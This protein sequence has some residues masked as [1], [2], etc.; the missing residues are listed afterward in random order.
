MPRLLG[1]I[2]TLDNSQKGATTA[3]VNTFLT[4]YAPLASPTFTGTP[5]APTASVGTNTTQIATTA[6]V[7]A[8]AGSSSS[9][10]LAGNAGTTP[11]TQFI[12]T[13]DAQALKFRVNNV[14]QVSIE[15]SGSWRLGTPSAPG[16]TGMERLIINDSD[17]SLSDFAFIAA[18]GGYPTLNQGKSRGTPTVR[19]AIINNDS[20]GN[21]LWWGYDGSSWLKGAELR[22]TATSV[23][24]GA[25]VSRFDTLVDSI[26]VMSAYSTGVS[27]NGTPL[28]PT[29]AF[30]TNTT[31]VATTAF[32]QGAVASVKVP[33]HA[34]L[35][36]GT[37]EAWY[38]AGGLAGTALV[39]TT[40]TANRLYAVPFSVT[41]TQTLDRLAFNVT[42]AS[43]N[44]FARVGIYQTTGGIS[45]YPT[46]L[47]YDS[48]SISMTGT[49]LK[50]ASTAISVTMTPGLYWFVFLTDNS[51]GVNGI[52][53]TGAPPVFGYAKSLTGAAQVG[54]YV[55]YTYDVLPDTFPSGASIQTST[56]PGIFAR[57]SS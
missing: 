12:G 47:V 25:L 8:N 44:H 27:L 31:Q 36:S 7:L 24:T 21:H 1:S 51:P 18:N 56:F 9:W 45:L 15:T 28:A 38:P 29:A 2:P 42:T 23:S 3:W 53:V 54:L 39:A 13:T 35:I 11:A 10:R 57:F 55:A 48:G 14:E 5:T 30:G 19:T 41:K 37:L 17:G 26:T 4:S 6:F 43:N 16:I 50:N 49:G 40:T 33:K 34:G 52:V 20:L 22:A 46:S 32:V